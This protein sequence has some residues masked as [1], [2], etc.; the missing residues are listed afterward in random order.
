MPDTSPY[1]SDCQIPTDIE[2]AKTAKT[3]FEIN[4]KGTSSQFFI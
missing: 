2:N 3:K 4:T 1:I